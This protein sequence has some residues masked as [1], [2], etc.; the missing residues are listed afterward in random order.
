[1]QSDSSVGKLIV[2][3]MFCCMQSLC[4]IIAYCRNDGNDNKQTYLQFWAWRRALPLRLECRETPKVL[5]HCLQGMNRDD[6]RRMR[7]VRGGLRC[8]VGLEHCSVY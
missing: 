4:S 7:V 5:L 2:G 6:V 8:N 3:R 1:M